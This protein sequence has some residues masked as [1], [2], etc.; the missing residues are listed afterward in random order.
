MDYLRI[1]N[2]LMKT[3]VD[4]KQE[5]KA[6]KKRGSYFERHHI[7]PLSMGGNKSYAIGSDNIVLLTAR[8]HYIAHRLLWL[9]YRTREMGFGFHKMVFS[10]SPL[11]ERR[12]D[13]RAYEAAKLAMSQCQRGENNP[14]WGRISPMK[15]R[16]HSE[17]N[18]KAHSERMKGKFIGDLNPSKSKEAREKI[19]KALRGKERK[20]GRG[21]NSSNYGGLKLLIENDL[22]V[23]EFERLE[24]MLSLVP[25]SIYNLR[26][27][28]RS[29]S[30]GKIKGR[31]QVMYEEDYKKSL[32]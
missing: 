4:I 19:S 12:F 15:G 27:H 14:M 26:N 13:S 7:T 29:R 28:L 2:N 3:T 18:K 23:G 1:Y 25:T 9:I 30:G 11:Q 24:D 16:T 22:I 10:E 32:E 5:R 17:E 31:W 6:L 21:S 20:G 8:E